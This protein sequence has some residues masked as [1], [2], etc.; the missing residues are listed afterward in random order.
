MKWR[1]AVPLAGTVSN[2]LFIVISYWG[3]PEVAEKRGI[4]LSA[5]AVLQFTTGRQSHQNFL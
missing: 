4:K 1:S 5:C 3:A 2:V